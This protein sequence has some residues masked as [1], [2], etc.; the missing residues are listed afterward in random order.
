[1]K[2]LPT[3]KQFLSEC[4]QFHGNVVPSDLVEFAQMHVEAALRN[5]SHQLNLNG[6]EDYDKTILYSYPLDNI[7]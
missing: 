6:V 5:A 3:A 1:M 4:I 7:K 2:K